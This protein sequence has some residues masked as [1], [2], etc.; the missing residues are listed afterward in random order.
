MKNII[1]FIAP[2]K[3]YIIYIALVTVLTAAIALIPPRILGLLFDNVIIPAPEYSSALIHFFL[4]LVG[5][6]ILC[7]LLGL[8]LDFFKA[9]TFASLSRRFMKDL[10]LRIF[11]RLCVLSAAF[12]NT[13]KKGVLL[14]RLISD[15]RQFDE[16]FKGVISSW[17]IAPFSLVAILIIMLTINP[18]LTIVS[19]LPA[20]IIYLCIW[21][22]VRLMRGKF[23][24]VRES[25]E[26]LSSLAFERLSGITQV[27]A[28]RGEAKSIASFDKIL[29]KQIKLRLDLD[30]I[31]S[32]YYPI[33]GFLSSTGIVLALLYGGFLSIGKEITGGQ[34]VMFIAY[35]SYVYVPMMNL[36][37]A[38]HVLQSLKSLV[39]GIEEILDSGDT[40]VSGT[41]TAAEDHP[42]LVFENV[43]FGYD[44]SRPVLS[45]I[46]LRIHSGERIGIIGETGA[47]KTTI[48]KL[49]I[50]LYDPDKGNILL[51]PNV[52][53]EL[54]LDTLR[55]DIRL[56]MQDDILF[57]GTVLENL[58]FPQEGELGPQVESICDRVA[59]HKFVAA[60]PHGYKTVIG[61]RG[62]RLS[63]GERQRISIAR[64]LLASPKILILDEATSNLDKKT[65]EEVLQGIIEL[66]TGR[67][68][69]MI[70]HRESVMELA[71]NVY[72][73]EGGILK[74]KKLKQPRV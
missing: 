35:L 53:K 40:V 46:N 55:G 3:R 74:L 29:D 48:A 5:I 4:Y 14:N 39:K 60:L 71:E 26:E 21:F 43:L 72:Q 51:G 37:R 57:D 64:A 33:L 44:K 41:V 23:E 70:S 52:I 18:Y 73:L 16:L 65:E 42:D 49:V 10:R 25:E 68:I 7:E 15:T 67:T 38:N 22:F 30:R 50:R 45:K 34:V 54:K 58:L 59:V 56:V 11:S 36:T 27:Q 31:T 8:V 20:P 62:C 66:M 6:Y 17:I 61:E 28:L 19:L 1:R 32:R 2:Y 63:A 13:N 47:G 12:H 9:V 69:I 24:A